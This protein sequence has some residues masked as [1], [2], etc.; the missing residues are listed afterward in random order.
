VDGQV[1][2]TRGEL[3]YVVTDVSGE[4]PPALLDSLRELPETVRLMR[5]AP[6]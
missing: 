6:S 3:G 1:L 4:L 2:A 5:F